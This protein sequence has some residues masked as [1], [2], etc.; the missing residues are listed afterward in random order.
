MLETCLSQKVEAVVWETLSVST[1]L[2]STARVQLLVRPANKGSTKAPS[3]SLPCAALEAFQPTGSKR[4]RA[5]PN[6]VQHTTW[7]N[8]SFP[9]ILRI[10]EAIS[11]RSVV[12]ALTGKSL[13]TLI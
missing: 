9:S 1:N 7:C 13:L 12:F 11:S 10:S 4:D 2:T 8:D 6:K 3:C 5:A